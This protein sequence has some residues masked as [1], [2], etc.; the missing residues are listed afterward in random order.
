MKRPL[1]HR[2]FSAWLALLV[3]TAS[4]GLTV[5]QHTCRVSGR[6]TASIV[7]APHEHGCP[8]AQ[9][10]ASH[11][12]AAA[13]K[14]QVAGACCEFGAHFHK[15]DAPSAELHWVKAPV[16]VLAPVWLDHT[17]WPQAPEP[18]RLL[19]GAAR[20][21]AADSSPPPRAGRALLTFVGVLIV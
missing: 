20:W 9:A 16:P 6:H 4:V 10:A 13:G 5:Q 17:A 15:L 19:S 11:A 18:L 14:T 1:L 12:T 8:P 3:L 21:H 7:F 2:L